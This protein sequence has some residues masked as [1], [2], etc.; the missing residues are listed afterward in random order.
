MNKK[1]GR[2]DPKSPKN[3]V[4]AVSFSIYN[5]ATTKPKNNEPVL[6]RCDDRSYIMEY[7]KEK[8]KW[9]VTE[10]LEEIPECFIN[11]WGRVP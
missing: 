2:H 11:W 5:P 6:C 7:V 10:T 1:I 9:Y 8:D 4:S 3:R